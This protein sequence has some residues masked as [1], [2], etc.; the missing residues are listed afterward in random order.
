MIPYESVLIAS[1]TS[2][3]PKFLQ[4]IKDFIRFNDA[5]YLG[6]NLEI[7]SDYKKFRKIN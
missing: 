4:V 6:F 3:E 7:S 1:L 5:E 2:D